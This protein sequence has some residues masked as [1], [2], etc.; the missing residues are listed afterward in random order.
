MAQSTPSSG[1]LDLPEAQLD[2]KFQELGWPKYRLG[3]VLDWVFRKR[4]FRYEGMS[5]LPAGTRSEL[6]ESL[7]LLL[8][9]LL[10]IQGS[11]DTTWKFLLRLADG[12]MIETVLIPAS[13]ALYGEKSDRLT[14]CVSSQ[15]G[16]AYGCK[17]C[18]SGL[19]GWK[20][21]LS[22]SEIVGQ[23]LLVEQEAKVRISNL[24]FMGMGEPFANYDNLLTAISWLNSG[25]G[26]GLGARH[27]T[28]STS[29]LVPRILDFADQPLQLRL[30]I[31]LH[32]ATDSVR[33]LIMPVNRRYPLAE[34]L[35]ACEYF[36]SKKAQRITFEYILIHG[37]NDQPEQAGELSRL[38]R[39]LNAKVNLIPYNQVEGL[40]W[41]RPSVETQDAFLSR[42]KSL[43]VAATLRR[44]K[45]HDIA[46]ACGQLRLAAT[47]SAS[48]S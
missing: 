32:G 22:P 38:V 42:L 40:E 45:G 33:E 7:P 17:F 34:L 9:Q 41:Q 43:G 6:A 19:D 2:E 37:I 26:V 18:A 24:V 23:V 16:C 4:V 8:P 1:L 5:N 48:E 27:M 47:K 20:R 29:G 46:A 10:R 44:E 11:Q 21:N 13:P 36:C 30:A 31:S 28:V 3:Q 25:K 14:L 12:Q 35:A 39:R 15:V